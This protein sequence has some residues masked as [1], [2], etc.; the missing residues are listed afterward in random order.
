M[1]RFDPVEGLLPA[2]RTMPEYQALEDLDEVAARYGVDPADVIKIDGNEN[3]FGPSP[4][5]LDALRR[6]DYHVE[7]Y[8]DDEQTALRA[9]LA[10]R[11]GV[12]AACVVAG[13][14]SDELIEQVFRMYLGAGETIVTVSPTFG[15]YA[16]DAGLHG[17]RVMDVPLRDDWS[18]DGDALVEAA[19]GAKAVFIASPNNP[20]GGLLPEALADRLLE[21]RALL[22]VDEAYIEFSGA[23][24]LAARAAAE[25]GLLVLRT[26]SKWGG[27]AGLRVGYG[28]MSPR[29]ADLFRRAKQPY[30]VNVA[31]EAAAIA[32]IADAAILDERA[33]IIVGERERVTRE[34]ARL[35][36]IDP[37]PSHANFVLMRLTRG[38]GRTVRDA[39]RRRGIFTRY[40]EAPRL[41]RHLR[42]SIAKP[43]Q[44]DR[45]IAAIREIGEE[46]AHG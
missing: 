22:V 42:I 20:T 25:E 2:L 18:I 37:A 38:D 43:E 24:S 11:L 21:S 23:R 30:N 15:M 31:A 9:A 1:A 6:V 27:L 12:P 3:P 34:L 7:W 19:R 10:G 26:L 39:L 41:R 33:R 8:G 44:N 5:A 4:R 40:F 28:V 16:F 17:T 35:E 46:L 32:S 29:M 14:G 13:A 45:V 36:W